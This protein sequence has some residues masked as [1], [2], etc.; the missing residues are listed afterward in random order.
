MISTLFLMTLTVATF[1]QGFKDISPSTKELMKLTLEVKIAHSGHLVLRWIIDNIYIKTNPAGNLKPDIEKST[2]KID[3][4]V[5]TIMALDRAIR[6][7]VANNSVYDERGILIIS[8]HMY[9]FPNII[10][11]M[12][13]QLKHNKQSLR[14]IVY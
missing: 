13:E 12:G 7:G 2:E 11:I 10:V 1:R 8:K 3:C 6:Y 14:F 4:A 9:R 5:A